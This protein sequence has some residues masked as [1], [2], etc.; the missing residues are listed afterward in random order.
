MSLIFNFV[1][2]FHVDPSYEICL[3]LLIKLLVFCFHFHID[4]IKL[5]LTIG[6]KGDT[7]EIIVNLAKAIDA[8][9]MATTSKYLLKQLNENVKAI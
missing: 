7:I 2:F 8:Y 1:S 5:Q 3:Q 9:S 4:A 6:I